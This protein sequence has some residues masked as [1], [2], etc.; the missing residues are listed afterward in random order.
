MAYVSKGFAN[1]GARPGAGRK[2]K[3][4]KL[5]EEAKKEVKDIATLEFWAEIAKNDAVPRLKKILNESK[6]DRSAVSAIQE[7]FNRALGKPPDSL[8]LSGEVKS[9]IS[10][11][12]GTG[13]LVDNR[14]AENSP[15]QEAD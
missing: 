4:E 13:V 9:V 6:D 7:V 8:K 12:N 14:H 1:G 5:L 11:F 2:L 15:A 10:L 3:R